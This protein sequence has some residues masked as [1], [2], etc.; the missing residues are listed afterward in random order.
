[1]TAPPGPTSL[2]R[3]VR[4]EIDHAPQN[5]HEALLAWLEGLDGTLVDAAEMIWT[6]N[7]SAHG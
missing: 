7:R 6:H 5:V 1:M 4:R 3:E 2:D